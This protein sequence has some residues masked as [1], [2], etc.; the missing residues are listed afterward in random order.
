MGVVAGGIDH[1]G[2]AARAGIAVG[3]VIREVNRQPIRT[4]GDFQAAVRAIDPKAPVLM[5]IQRGDFAV[6][7]ALAPS[8]R[9]GRP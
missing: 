7:V 8:S 2:P 3:D 1:S 5:L 4:M 6:Y 9:E